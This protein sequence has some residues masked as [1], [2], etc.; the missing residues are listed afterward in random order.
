[1]GQLKVLTS[2]LFLLGLL[3][4]ASGHCRG[5][6][7]VVS[8]ASDEPVFVFKPE[9]S[10]QCQ[11]TTGVPIAKVAE[12]LGPIEILSQSTR[13]DGK[14][15]IALCGAATGRIHVFQIREKDLAGALSAGF[16]LLEKK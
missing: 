9:G 1:M 12:D 4:C 15:H 5:S 14:M 2:G 3:G 8:S 16:Q 10:K 7:R 13:S 11:P 6:Q